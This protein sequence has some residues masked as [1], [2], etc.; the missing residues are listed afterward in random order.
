MLDTR[1]LLTR[2]RLRCTTQRRALYEA[3]VAD[4][5]HPTAEKLYRTV[6]PGA[7]GLSRATVYN[8][9]ET[10]CNAG[11]ARKLPSDNGCCRYDA[12]VSEHLHVCCREDG[13]IRDVPVELGDKLTRELPHHVI[14]EI[15]SRMG[16]EIEGISIQLVATRRP[17]GP[18]APD[19]ISHR[20]RGRDEIHFGNPS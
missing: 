11:L 18:A 15:E 4:K 17:S 13:S 7:T 9:L 19:E 14:A 6:K 1:E 12:D 8:T 2:P 20:C 10:L 16:V 3:L 5:S